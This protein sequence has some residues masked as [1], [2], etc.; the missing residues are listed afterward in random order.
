MSETEIEFSQ[1]EWQRASD[2]AVE[3]LVALGP[4]AQAGCPTCNPP[5]FLLPNYQM[6]YELAKTLRERYVD[7]E[8]YNMDMYGKHPVDEVSE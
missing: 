5:R 8:T 7:L 1:D 6:K 3:L 2:L 4:Q